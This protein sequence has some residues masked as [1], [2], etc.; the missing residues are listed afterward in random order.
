MHDFSPDNPSPQGRIVLSTLT[1]STLPAAPSLPS[2]RA[3]L[4]DERAALGTVGREHVLCFQENVDARCNFFL[5]AR[6]FH[7][8]SVSLARSRSTRLRGGLA[9]PGTPLEP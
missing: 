8:A 7:Q 6:L 2:D 9:H 4:V 1:P 5:V 3:C